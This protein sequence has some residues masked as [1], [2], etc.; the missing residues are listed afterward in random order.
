MDPTHFYVIREERNRV[1]VNKSPVA[2]R[3]DDRPMVVTMVDN[4]ILLLIIK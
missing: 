4:S 2:M 1:T 3:E